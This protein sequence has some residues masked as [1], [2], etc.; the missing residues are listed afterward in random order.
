MRDR[1]SHDLRSSDW[2]GAWITFRL[3][4]ASAAG[5]VL[6]SQDSWLAWGLGTLLLTGCLLQWF[7]VLHEC[8]HATLFATPRLDVIVGHVAGLFAGFPFATWRA[9]HHQ[10]HRWTGWQ[11]KD[12]TTNIL[13]PREL[14]PL[15]KFAMD[16]CWRLWIPVFAVVYRLN[17][18]WNLPRLYELF[19]RPVHRR[20]HRRAVLVQAGFYSIVLVGSIALFG[21]GPIVKVI[22][23]PLLVSNQ[24]LDVVLLS[25]HTHVPMQVAGEREVEPFAYADQVR[26]TRSL[27][28]PGWISRWLFLGFDAHELHHELPRTPGYRLAKI[29]RPMPGEVAPL[30]W[31]LAAKRIPAHVFLYSNRDQSGLDI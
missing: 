18:Y 4:L 13:V 15:T 8:G 22:G 23:L 24:I 29:R 5:L 31:A 6:A 26:F 30:A 1:E 7:F 16:W 3:A 14:P 12:P 2:I 25:Q 20:R 11:D 27:R 19:P 28:C 9:I 10:H 21:L 17:N